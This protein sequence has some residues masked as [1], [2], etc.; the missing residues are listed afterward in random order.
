M[1]P[2]LSAVSACSPQCTLRSSSSTCAATCPA[3]ATTSCSAPGSMAGMEPAPPAAAECCSAR[4]TPLSRILRSR[5]LAT[6]CVSRPSRSTVPSS[7]R[8][9]ASVALRPSGSC[10][11]SGRD[12]PDTAPPAAARLSASKL[13]WSRLAPSSPGGP[14]A[15]LGRAAM[16]GP[17]GYAPPPPSGG[18]WPPVYVASDWLSGS[19]GR[20][21][22]R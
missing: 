14:A 8:A 5:L 22:R 21:R 15:A 3:S 17:A 19:R 9:L 16:T 7:S 10:R 11:P 2:T 18:A 12:R 4:G 6:N 1:Q 13:R 20:G